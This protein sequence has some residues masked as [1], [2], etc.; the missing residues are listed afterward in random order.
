M[1]LLP[2]HPKRATIVTSFEALDML[3]HGVV[4]LCRM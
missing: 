1:L 4:Q 3:E 2:V